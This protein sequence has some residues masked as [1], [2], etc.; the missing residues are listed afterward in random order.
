MKVSSDKII[1]LTNMHQFLPL[2]RCVCFGR[3]PKPGFLMTS[4]PYN[5]N[6][7]ICAA[8]WENE[9]ADQLRS[10][11]EAVQRLFFATSLVQFLLY[12]YQVIYPKFQDSSFL[13]KIYRPVSF[14]N[15]RPRRLVFLHHGSFASRLISKTEKSIRE[16][17]LFCKWRIFGL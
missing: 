12:L 8:P 6:T 2:Y 13:L 11:C 3:R 15:V 14:E 7:V 9:G 1:I 17:T 4:I 16:R 10:H 5:N